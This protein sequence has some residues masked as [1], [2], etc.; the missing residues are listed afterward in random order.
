MNNSS[1]KPMSRIWKNIKGKKLTVFFSFPSYLPDKKTS[2]LLCLSVDKKDDEQF[3]KQCHPVL[4]INL[5]L[6]NLWESETLPSFYL[7]KG[8]VII[9]KTLADNLIS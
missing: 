1:Q 4:K 9:P 6:A 2:V 8:R 7:N 3:T 5:S